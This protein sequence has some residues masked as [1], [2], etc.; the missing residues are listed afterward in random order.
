[1]LG[2]KGSAEVSIET[3]ISNLEHIEASE[4]HSD[5]RANVRAELK[6][7]KRNIS[8]VLRFVAHSSPLEAADSPELRKAILDVRR[9]CLLINGMISRVLF[10]QVFSARPERWASYAARAVEHYA[11]MTHAACQICLIAMPRHA[12]Q[13]ANAL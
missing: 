10:L 3:L 7:M 5:I 9:E 8:A 4:L 13:L 1:M 2:D 12:Q 11:E 6:R